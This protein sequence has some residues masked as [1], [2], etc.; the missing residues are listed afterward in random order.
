M[1]ITLTGLKI[2]AEITGQVRVR[3]RASV[4]KAVGGISV[5]NRGQL[6]VIRV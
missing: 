5:I 6:S 2:K 3:V 4:R 1:T